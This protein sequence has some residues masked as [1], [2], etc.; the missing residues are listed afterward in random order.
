M[1]SNPMP[2]SVLIALGSNLGDRGLFLRRAIHELAPDVRVVRVSSVHETEPV[3]APPNSPRFLNMVVAGHT[4]LPPTVLLDKL[5]AIERR[6][7]RHRTTIRNAPRTIDLDLILHSAHLAHSR[8]LTLPHPRY[9][10][11]EFVMRPAQELKLGWPALS[12]SEE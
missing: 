10:Q 9:R 5:L 4:A 1:T 6:L 3:D 12:K 2:F 8:Q 7:G 11:R